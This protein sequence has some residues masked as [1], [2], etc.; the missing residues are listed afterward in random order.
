MDF[1]DH[2][3]SLENCKEVF[4]LHIHSWRNNNWLWEDRLCCLMWIH[5]IQQVTSLWLLTK[6]GKP[7]KCYAATTNNQLWTFCLSSDGISNIWP[8]KK[9][10]C[11]SIID[12][13]LTVHHQWLAISTFTTHWVWRNSPA[14]GH[15]QQQ[16]HFNTLL[17]QIFNIGS[18]YLPN[19]SI[20][21][22]KKS[23]HLTIGRI[24][25]FG[26]LISIL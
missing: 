5:Y 2:C 17:L 19:F 23:K 11:V 9:S 20:D 14:L 10:Y 21:K 26:G 12:W 6:Y 4:Y 1:C 7:S 18:K 15:F 22:G 8:S 3:V 24:A 13:Y 16:L 25:N